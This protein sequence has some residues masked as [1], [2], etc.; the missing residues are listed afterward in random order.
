[1]GIELEEPSKAP[2]ARIKALGPLPDPNKDLLSDVLGQLRPTKHAE[3]RAIDLLSETAVGLAQGFF[4]L[5]D[6]TFSELSVLGGL[7][8]QAVLGRRER[9]DFGCVSGSGAVSVMCD[10][11]SVII[12]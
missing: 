9:V 2:A 11:Q 3:R 7:G 1:M 12:V 8:D 5:V 6:Q 10:L 4:A